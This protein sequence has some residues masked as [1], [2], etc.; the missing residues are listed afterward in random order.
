[1][2]RKTFPAY[3]VK[4]DAAQ[5]IVEAVVSVLGNVDEGND[6]IWKG[7]FTKTITERGHKIRVLDQH[8]TDSIM[9]VFGKPL[10][11]REVGREEL[12]PEVLMRFPEAT[13]GLKVAVQCLMDTPEGRGAFARLAAGAVDEWSI[14]YDALDVDYTKERGPDG[15]ERTVRNLR[16]IRLWEFSAVLWGMNEATATVAAKEADVDKHMVPAFKA[17]DFASTFAQMEAEEALYEARY[18]MDRAFRQTC[19]DIMS[20]GEMTAADKTTALEEA[21]RQYGEAL[22]AWCRRAV[23][24]MGVGEAE[25]AGR[26]ISRATATVLRSA[27]DAIAGLLVD[28]STDDQEGGGEDN[29]DDRRQPKEQES[30]SQSKGTGP[31]D[32]PPAAGGGP[33]SEPSIPVDPALIDL[34]IEHNAMLL[35]V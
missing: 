29:C 10:E 20:D 21:S 7:A 25:K 13:G 9:R 24:L 4:A 22:G 3:L 5:G 16:T 27:M 8:Q 26:R 15:K 33:G 28:A 30:T 12:P 23:E 19:D 32:N 35:E 18:K 2:E 11:V 31:A 17:A 34:E 1:M 14:G 6:R